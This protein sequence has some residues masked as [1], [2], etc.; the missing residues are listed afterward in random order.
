MIAPGLETH[1]G[2]GT[3]GCKGFQVQGCVVVLVLGEQNSEGWYMVVAVGRAYD[4]SNSGEIEQF[5]PL[6]A[7]KAAVL[8]GEGSP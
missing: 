3:V 7:P 1:V 4:I 5:E 8:P 2:T 6:V